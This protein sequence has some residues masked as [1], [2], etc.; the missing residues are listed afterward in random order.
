MSDQ[1]L[2]T[3]AIKLAKKDKS[4]LIRMSVD[5]R[6]IFDERLKESGY[7]AAGAFVRDYVINSKP[8]RR[9]VIIPQAQKASEHLVELAQMIMDDNEKELLIKKIMYVAMNIFGELDKVRLG[10]KG[11]EGEGYDW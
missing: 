3:K 1:V 6:A 8:K 7:K 4:L 5:E 2:T 10:G 9:Y 11:E